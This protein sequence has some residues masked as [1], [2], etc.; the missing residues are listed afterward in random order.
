MTRVFDAAKRESR[1]GWDHGVDEAAPSLPFIF[2]NVLATLY[3]AGEYT[4]GKAK[5]TAIGNE[6]GIPFV[7]AG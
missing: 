5:T 6:K 4:R 2:C 3:V 1:V 7:D